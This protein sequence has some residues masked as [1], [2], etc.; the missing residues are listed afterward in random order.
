M[1]NKVQKIINNKFSRVF[2]FVF[3]LRYLIAIFFVAIVLF[4]FI[5]QFFDYT[6]KEEIIKNFLSQ[7]YGLK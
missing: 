4:L 2:K 3:F 7:N 5:P 6:K 1:I